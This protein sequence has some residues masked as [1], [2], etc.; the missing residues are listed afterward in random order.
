MNQV[1]KACCIIH[2]MVVKRRMRDYTGTARFR[3]R[4][5]ESSLPSD[6]LLVTRGENTY[7]RARFWREF[8]DPIENAT[9]N[10]AL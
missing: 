9:C 8:V 5:E 3:L 6:V 4:K 2:N 10:R 1:V 7:D